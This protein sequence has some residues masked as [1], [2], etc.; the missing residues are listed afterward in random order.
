LGIGCDPVGGGGG[1]EGLD[2]FDFLGVFRVS[3]S[4]TI[5]GT[6]CFGFV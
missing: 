6:Y 3:Q 1:E 2:S 4:A 5:P